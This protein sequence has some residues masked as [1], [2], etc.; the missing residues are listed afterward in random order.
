MGFTFLNDLRGTGMLALLLKFVMAIIC[1]GIIGLERGTKGQAAGFRT[2]ILVCTG[3]C[4]TMVTGQYVYLYVSP[5]VDLLRI[6]AQVVSGI[7]FLGVGTIVSTKMNRVKGLT[8]A[9]GLWAASCIG[10]AIGIGYYEAALGGTLVVLIAIVV[11]QKIDEIFYAKSPIMDL[12]IEMDNMEHF[13]MLISKIRSSGMK[14]TS[15]EVKKPRS[16]LRDGIGVNISVKKTDRKSDID[17]FGI[18]SETEG[19]AF[20]EEAF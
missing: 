10:L 19:L 16:G 3:A 14:I 20:I 1:G 13:K 8:T 17:M 15:M 6:G 5:Q 2:H 7:G 9:A 11:L 12:Y 18:I 4:I